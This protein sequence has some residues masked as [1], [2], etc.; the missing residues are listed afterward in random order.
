MYG[1]SRCF[2]GLFFF[3]SQQSPQQSQHLRNEKHEQQQDLAQQAHRTIQE[4]IERRIRETMM[5]A[6]MTGHLKDVSMGSVEGGAVLTCNT[7]LP[8]SCSSWRTSS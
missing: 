8:C 3:P 2:M 7:S 1:S 4:R 5:I 6:I